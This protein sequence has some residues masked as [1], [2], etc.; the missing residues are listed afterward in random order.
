MRDK[1]AQESKS[2]EKG[3]DP[4]LKHIDLQFKQQRL[5]ELEDYN[6]AQDNSY[7][8]K[9]V[10]NSRPSIKEEINENLADSIERINNDSGRASKT[11]VAVAYLSKSPSKN[12]NDKSQYLNRNSQSK[13]AKVNELMKMATAHGGSSAKSKAKKA[14]LTANE[15]SRYYENMSMKH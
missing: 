3:G 7:C 13:Y 4:L 6:A 11:H 9:R 15:V 14:G 12:N 1:Q 2:K 10:K 5:K 8:E